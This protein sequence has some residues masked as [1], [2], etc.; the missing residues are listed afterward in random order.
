MNNIILS[1]LIPTYNYKKGI[2]RIFNCIKSINP[3]Y[4]ESIEVIICD[5]SEKE[6]LD[7]NKIIELNSKLRN[8]HYIKNQNKLGATHNW[9]KLIKLSRGKYYWLLHHDEYWDLKNDFI[10]YLINNILEKNKTLFLLPINKHKNYIIGSLEFIISQKQNSFQRLIMQIIKNPYILIFINIFGPPSSII[11]SNKF[12]LP[13][14]NSLKFLVDVDLYIRLLKRIRAK[15]LYIFETN[16]TIISCQN[17]KSSI[18]KILKV[19]SKN[20]KNIEINK[21]LIKYK[22]KK[23]FFIFIKIICF[24]LIYKVYSFS[25]T[26]IIGFRLRK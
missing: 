8:F 10:G 4:Y 17:N 5:D 7:K 25:S 13:Y 20:I 9:N 26:K 2:Y 23:D 16:H 6:I 15:E 14:D 24:Y 22:F 1:I 19:N 11:I 12:K 18:T 21:L 3:K